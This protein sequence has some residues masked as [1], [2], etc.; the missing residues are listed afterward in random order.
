M[1]LELYL[2]LESPEKCTNVQQQEG[3]K[4]AHLNHPWLPGE[5]HHMINI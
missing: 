1:V 4:E 2:L 5:P 3:S